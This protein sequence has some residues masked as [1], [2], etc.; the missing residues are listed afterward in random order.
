MSSDIG[1]WSTHMITKKMTDVGA[2]PVTR[3]KCL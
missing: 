1:W 2:C 3:S